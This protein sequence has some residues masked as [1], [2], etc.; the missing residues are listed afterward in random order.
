MISDF[1]DYVGSKIEKIENGEIESYPF[2]IQLKNLEK[3]I[4]EAYTQIE[5]VVIDDIGNEKM[6]FEGFQ[7]EKR[8]GSKRWNFSHLDS[9]I[10]L[11]NKLKDVENLHIMAYDRQTK[12]L[13]PLIDSETGEV[14]EPASLSYTKDSLVVTKLKKNKV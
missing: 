14:I 5:S 9:H 10:Q 6:S 8:N 12:G 1:K 13:E 7:I 3:V 11:K 4:K 2:Y